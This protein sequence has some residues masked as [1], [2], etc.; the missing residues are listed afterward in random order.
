MRL[1]VL[2][3]TRVPGGADLTYGVPI[4]EHAMGRGWEV[5][6][7]CSARPAMRPLAERMRSIATSHHDC[8]LVESPYRSWTYRRMT[9]RFAGRTRSILESIRP[10][11]VLVVLPYMTYGLGIMQ[12]CRDLGVPVVVVYQVAKYQSLPSWRS[13]ATRELLTTHGRAIAVSEQNRRILRSMFGLG[14]DEVDLVHNG[15]GPPEIRADAR[16][17]VRRELRGSL[18]LRE[19]QRLLLTTAR[20]APQKGH[21]IL[22]EAMP[23]VLEAHPDCVLALAGDGPDRAGL[24]REIARR[25]LDG[26]IRLLGHR[27]DTEALAIAADLFV[28]PTLYE[29]SPFA[30][31]EAMR[32]GLPIVTTDASGILEVV[33]PGQDGLVARAGD[34]AS[35]RDT[36]LE[37]LASPDRMRERGE[38]ARHRVLAEFSAEAMAQRTLAILEAAPHASIAAAVPQ[39]P[40]PAAPERS[41]PR[42]SIVICTY[43]REESLAETLDSLGE[44]TAPRSSF[45]VI[46]VDNNSPD[47]T[48]EI[49][50]RFAAANPNVRYLLETSQGLN[51]ARNAGFRAAAADWVLYLDDDVRAHPDLVE[52]AIATIDTQDFDCF[53]GFCLPWFKFGRP[54]WLHDRYVINEVDPNVETGVLRDGFAMGALVAFRRSVLEALGGFAVEHATFVGMNKDKIAYGDETMLQVRMRERGFLVGFEPS[55]KVDH[56]VQRN[57]LEPTWFLRVRFAKGRDSWDTFGVDPT[58]V[59]LLKRLVSVVLAPIRVLPQNVGRFVTSADYR[60]TNLVLDTLLPA[61]RFLGEIH[62]GLLIMRTRRRPSRRPVSGTPRLRS[63]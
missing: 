32:V 12:A 24:E 56:L 23:P 25:G 48:R 40:H 42:V 36:M 47:R 33:R 21:S 10:D 16:E 27:E 2:F 49:V 43:R 9:G 20:L 44:Q 51:F 14:R 35:L 54:S 4:V 53:G 19:D 37:A 58:P 63:E 59:R 61:A 38:S 18:G 17:A 62:G 55:M 30:L 60:A 57:R 26:R 46:V 15:I 8:E 11:R 41:N 31:L 34:V 5:H 6:T 50:D 39:R 52:R 28:F 3:T 45:E 7:A 13:A 29:G 1:L 22:I